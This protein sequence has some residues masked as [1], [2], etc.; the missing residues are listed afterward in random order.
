MDNNE[1]GRS[2]E[3]DHSGTAVDSNLSTTHEEAP[4]S[5]ASQHPLPI[6][7]GKMVVNGMNPDLKYRYLSCS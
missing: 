7:K 6:D 1:L 4:I 5:S 2:A 3:E